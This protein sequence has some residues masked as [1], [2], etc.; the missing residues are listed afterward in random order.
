MSKLRA[1]VWARAIGV[2]SVVLA[3]LL[4][5][6]VALPGAAFAML[7]AACA[8]LVSLCVALVAEVPPA[9]GAGGG[10]F[11]V[12]LVAAVL[13]L[14]IAAAPLAPGAQRPVLADLLWLPLLALLGTLLLC[15][16]AGFFGLRTGLRLARRSGGR[17]EPSPTSKRG[18][19]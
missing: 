13:G 1:A 2:L 5:R 14:T 4:F 18:G 3:A 15:S 16:A 6:V 12:A 7:L 17:G 10:L 9:V 19:D 8:A 11:A